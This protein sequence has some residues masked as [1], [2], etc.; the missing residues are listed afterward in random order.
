MART[1]QTARRHA[2]R[3]S[4][5]GRSQFLPTVEGS[6]NSTNDVT[7]V[8]SKKTTTTLPRTTPTTN[9]NT[10]PTTNPPPFGSF[11]FVAPTSNQR[12]TSQ[13]PLPALF[14]TAKDTTT[15]DITANDTT[16]LC[17]TALQGSFHFPNDTATN[18]VTANDT[19][20]TN[21]ARTKPNAVEKFHT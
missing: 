6:S 13:W 9:A 14:T 19:T 3:T 18:D 7:A 21:N 11:S 1:K 16:T 8:T 4:L 2:R 12:K 20:T 5:H 15:N 10:F 17:R